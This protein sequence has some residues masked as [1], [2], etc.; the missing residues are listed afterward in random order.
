MGDHFPETDVLALS[1]G[2]KGCPAPMTYLEE[3]DANDGRKT[4]K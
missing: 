3:L 1:P 4:S 2:T